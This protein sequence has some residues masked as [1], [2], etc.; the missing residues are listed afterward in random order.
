MIESLVLVLSEYQALIGVLI[1]GLATI[2]GS[3]LSSKNQ[4]NAQQDIFNKE[5]LQKEQETFWKLKYTLLIDFI[6]NRGAITKKPIEISAADPIK[7]FNALNRIDIVFFNAE[8]VLE[9]NKIFNHSIKNGEGMK[10][11][12]L[13]NL[14]VAIHEDLNLTPPSKESFLNP[15]VIN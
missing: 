14:A 2:L 12:E 6:G 1:G 11:D 7:L 9:A 8:K 15:L 10:V 3:Y 5:L 4:I 13:Y